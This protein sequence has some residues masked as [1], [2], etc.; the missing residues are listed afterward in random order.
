MRRK[1]AKSLRITNDIIVYLGNPRESTEKPLELVRENSKVA[2]Y[3]LNIEKSKPF[4]YNYNNQLEYTRQKIQFAV[5]AT[6]QNTQG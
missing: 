4:L 3:M 5:A 1:G 2:E 6:L